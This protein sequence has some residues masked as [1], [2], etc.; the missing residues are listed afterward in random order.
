MEELPKGP[1]I[2]RRRAEGTGFS[3]D[4][5]LSDFAWIGE[6]DEFKPDDECEAKLGRK[7]ALT[8]VISAILHGHGAT[9]SDFDY[10]FSQAYSALI[11]AKPR[12]GNTEHAAD[13]V[14]L[15]YM[16]SH[17]VQDWFGFTARKRDIAELC[18]AA[19]DAHPECRRLQ[20]GDDH[21]IRRL[22]R[23]FKKTKDW[24]SHFA[25]RAAD[26]GD[27]DPITVAL[28]VVGRLRHLGLATQE[29]SGKGSQVA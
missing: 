26:A 20:K 21:E 27:P 8:I 18:R 24:L 13:E 17:Y 2:L 4:L 7:L 16:A 25:L 3:P 22:R 14:L 23:K 1:H 28:Q 10:R 12:R 9:N 29:A 6:H 15:A 11:G 19:L 5:E